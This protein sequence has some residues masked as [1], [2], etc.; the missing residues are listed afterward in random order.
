MDVRCRNCAGKGPSCLLRLVSLPHAT[1]HADKRLQ[2]RLHT[3]KGAQQEAALR[4]LEAMGPGDSYVR[5]QMRQFIM[6]ATLWEVLHRAA[7][8]APVGMRVYYCVLFL[9]F[10]SR[11]VLFFLP[12]SSCLLIP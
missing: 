11:Q 10:C 2:L 8:S 6:D 12:F 5:E 7:R 9:R 1:T 3:M 4:A